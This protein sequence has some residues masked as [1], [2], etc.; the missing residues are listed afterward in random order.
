MY[1]INA[2]KTEEHVTDWYVDTDIYC[3]LWSSK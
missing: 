2:V 1:G 3:S